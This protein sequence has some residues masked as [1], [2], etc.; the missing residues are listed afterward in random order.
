VMRLKEV[1]RVRDM[2][3]R[4]V[5]Q[6]GGSLSCSDGRNIHDLGRLCSTVS[7]RHWQRS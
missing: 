4:P 1:A 7:Y 3:N 6:G 5:A 2:L